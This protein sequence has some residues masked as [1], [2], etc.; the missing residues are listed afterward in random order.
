MS[1]LVR[2]CIL[3][4][5][6]SYLSEESHYVPLWCEK[7]YYVSSKM[8]SAVVYLMQGHMSRSCHCG[9]QKIQMCLHLPWN[10]RTTFSL[11]T[12]QAWQ[13]KTCLDSKHSWDFRLLTPQLFVSLFIW[14]VSSSHNYIKLLWYIYNWT[15]AKLSMTANRVIQRHKHFFIFCKQNTECNTDYNCDNA[16]NQNNQCLTGKGFRFALLSKNGDKNFKKK[17]HTVI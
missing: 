1:A 2:A 8:G 10:K 12:S 9:N 5:R 17:K 14:I 11:V 7:Q 3:S 16:K 6:E 4:G 15:M 13:A